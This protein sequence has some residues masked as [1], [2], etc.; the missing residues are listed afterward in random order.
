MAKKYVKAGI[1]VEAAFVCPLICLF[2]CG[3][4]ALT[5]RLYGQVETYSEELRERELP[6]PGA[7]LVRLEVFVETMLQEVEEDAG[8]I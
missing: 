5:F 7:E 1:T 4:I 3:M 8:G 2:L 6:A